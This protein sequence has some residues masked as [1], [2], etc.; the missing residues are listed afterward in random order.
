MDND[1]NEELKTFENAFKSEVISKNPSIE[2]M[3]AAI[4]YDISASLRIASKSVFEINKKL[5]EIIL[6]QNTKSK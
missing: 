2:A 1:F 4:R 5:G 3:N 6:I